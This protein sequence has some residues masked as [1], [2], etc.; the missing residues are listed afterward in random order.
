[1]RNT[2]LRTLTFALT[3]LGLT[4]CDPADLAD[5]ELTFRPG[6]GLGGATFNTSNWVSPSVRD[7]YEFNRTGVWRTNTFGFETK[8]KKVTFQDPQLGLIS[9]DPASAPNPRGSRSPR[10]ATSR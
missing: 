9:T 10:G 4:G 2:A 8:L 5:D 7:V 6:S 1:M 3:T